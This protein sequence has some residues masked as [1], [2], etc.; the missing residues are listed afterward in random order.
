MT[1]EMRAANAGERLPQ[2]IAGRELDALVAG[3]VMGWKRLT[4]GEVYP[5]ARFDEVHPE[6]AQMGLDRG[7]ISSWWWDGDA[8]Q[9]EPAEDLIDLGDTYRRFAPS[10]GAAMIVVE[11]TRIRRTGKTAACRRCIASTTTRGPTA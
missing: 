8:V 7:R 4:E 11:A 10:T 3:N 1:E 6:A 2:H 5:G 9:R